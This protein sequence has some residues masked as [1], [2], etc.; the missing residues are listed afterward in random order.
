VGLTKRLNADH[1]Q[2]FTTTAIIDVELLIDII[3][4]RGLIIQ[5]GSSYGMLQDEVS[6]YALRLMKLTSVMQI[7]P[8]HIKKC[9]VLEAQ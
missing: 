1:H 4:N 2:V 3:D 8:K 5:R 6:K 9:T 7:K